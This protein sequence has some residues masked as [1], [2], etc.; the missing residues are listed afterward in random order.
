MFDKK[1]VWDTLWVFH[2]PFLSKIIFY[3]KMDLRLFLF[4]CEELWEAEGLVLVKLKTSL[5]IHSSPAHSRLYGNN[6]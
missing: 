6:H 3:D 2:I 1:R 5:L 4:S